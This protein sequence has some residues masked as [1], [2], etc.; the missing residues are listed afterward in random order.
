MLRFGLRNSL[1]F[2]LLGLGSGVFLLSASMTLA[3]GAVGN[4]FQVWEAQFGSG[5]RS[6]GKT[7]AVVWGRTC[8]KVTGV[9]RS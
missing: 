8:L 2:E 9:C 4:H 3:Q 7:L 5:G 1:A 6:K